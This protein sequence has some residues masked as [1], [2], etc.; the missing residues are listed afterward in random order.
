ME[1]HGKVFRNYSEDGKLQIELEKYNP[2]QELYHDVISRMNAKGFKQIII[3]SEMM[4]SILENVLLAKEYILVVNFNDSTDESI[5]LETR[6]ILKKI[7]ENPLDFVKLKDL[8]KWALDNNSIDIFSIEVS[9][10][11]KHIAVQ[12]NGII[13]GTNIDDFFQNIIKKVLAGFL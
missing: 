9:N 10:Q 6:S 4:L 13:I 8:L 11:K 7:R 12:S 3:H 1:E 5:I 2:D